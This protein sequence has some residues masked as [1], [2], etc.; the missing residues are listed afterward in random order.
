MV[1]LYLKTIS[2]SLLILFIILLGF[3]LSFTYSIRMSV[4]KVDNILGIG[5][6]KALEQLLTSDKTQW[7]TTISHLFTQNSNIVQIIDIDSLR[8]PDTER[9]RLLADDIVYKDEKNLIFL[10][11]SIHDVYAYK[12]INKSS[13]VLKIQVGTSMND[14]I[15]SS[16]YLMKTIILNTLN[17]TPNNKWNKALNELQ[18]QYQLPL[19]LTSIHNKDISTQTRNELLHHD[20]SYDLPANEKPITTIYFKIPNSDKILSVGPL[21]YPYFSLQHSKI[22]IYFV[23][24]I[25]LLALI[26]VVILTLLFSRN[27]AKIHK[28]TQ[29][30]SQGHF[31]Y[32]VS[33]NRFSTLRGV[34]ENVITMGN[35][36]NLLMQSQQNMA[37]FVAHEVRTPLYTIQLAVDSLK[38]IKIQSHEEQEHIDSIQEDIQELNRL[39]STFLLYSQS[40]THELKVNKERLNLREWLESLLKTHQSYTVKVLFH[41]QQNDHELIYFDPKLCYHAVNNLIS[42]ALKHAHKEILIRLEYQVHS[43]IIRVDDDGPGVPESERERIVKPFTILNSSDTSGK[44]IGLGLSIT[45]TIV[46]LH[47]G[48]LAINHSKILKGAS[49]S[50]ILPR[51]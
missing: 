10:T 22:Q 33:L 48:K 17:T 49:F 1:K 18:L 44:H 21:N 31:N 16:T 24:T 29:E 28:L 15:K 27:S 7:Q 39:I 13:Y 20:V 40:T 3:Y 30:Y 47:E 51:T 4:Q 36:I 32:D 23:I 5:N 6:F 38:K 12:R 43:V 35:Q 45:K 25:T 26:S 41:Y 19:K 8:F 9:K 11:Y 50:L 46:S 37:R 2:A 42:N 34:Y 14:I